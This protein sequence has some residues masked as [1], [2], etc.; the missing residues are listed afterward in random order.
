MANAQNSSVQDWAS[1]LSRNDMV[2]DTLTTRWE[3]GVFTGNGSIGAM[4]YMADE[5]SFRLE[6]G[7]TDVTDHRREKISH[8]YGKARLPIGHFMISPTGKILKNSARLHLWDAEATGELIT[9]KGSIKWRTLTL[10]QSDIIV[11]ET[12][13]SGNEKP[14]F[15]FVPEESVSSRVKYMPDIPEGYGPNPPLKLFE[16]KNISFCRQPLLAGGD[17]TTAWKTN[18]SDKKESLFITVQIEKQ[19]SSVSKAEKQINTVSEKNIAGKI[20]QHRNWWHRFYPESFISIPDARMESFYWIQ[21]YKMASA[22]REGKI[23][24]DL[25]GPWYR[26][27]PWPAYWFNLNMQLI[28]SPTYAANRLSLAKGLLQM[29][30]AARNNLV[31]NVPE[32]YRHN[33]MAL[34]RSG[35]LDMYSPVKVFKERDPS[36]TDAQL[37]LG[38]LTWLLHNYWLHY[39]Y[40]MD[41]QIKKQ[42]IPLLKQSINYYLQLVYKENDGKWHLPYSYSP[43]YP[44]GVTRDCNYDL[45]LLRWGCQTLLDLAPVDPLSSKWKDILKNLIDYPQDETGLRIGRDVAFNQSHRHYSHL[46]MIYPLYTMNWDQPENRALILKSLNHWHSFKGALQGYSFTGGASIYATMGEGQKAVDYLNQLLD[47]YVKSNTMYLE[48]G[49]VI[50]TPLAAAASIQDLLLQSWSGKIRVFPAI[51]D[52]WKDVA[53]E[54]LRTEGAFLISASRKDGETQWVRIKSLAGQPCIINTGIKSILKTSSATTVIEPLENGF[55]RLHLKKN[56]EIILFKEGITHFKL[57]PVSCNNINQLHFWG[58]K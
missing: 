4:L 43:E 7:R 55:I 53:F 31:L 50:E 14:N 34:G 15:R 28:Y 44:G 58:K 8:L 25:M 17:Y 12:E 30:D 37:E 41:P 11:F 40:T 45:S 9:T 24:I 21:Q 18:V 2:Y 33:T 29:I 10:S 46:L 19:G 42:L 39:R 49:P 1:F 20:V 35:G 6:I 16:R 23:P 27:T 22:T 56:Q 5:N 3:D 48:T 32:P 13:S 47:R 38:N 57:R 54:N 26:Y 52:I 36:A 51:P